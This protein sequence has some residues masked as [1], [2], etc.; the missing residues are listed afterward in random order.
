MRGRKN[1]YKIVSKMA[2]SPV[3]AV[4]E[5]VGV[6]L[7]VADDDDGGAVVVVAGDNGLR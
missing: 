3:P 2:T 7:K 4:D 6:G 1:D 5:D